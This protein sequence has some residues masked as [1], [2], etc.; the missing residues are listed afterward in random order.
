[1]LA[2]LLAIAA[3][4]VAAA[5]IAILLLRHTLP[6]RH[7][8]TLL[9]H[10]DMRYGGA[11]RAADKH[12]LLSQGRCRLSLMGYF[13]FAIDNIVDIARYVTNIADYATLFQLRRLVGCAC[14]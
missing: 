9:C 14:C 1:M 2:A 3:T 7:I 5:I 12:M 6:L 4:V 11:I 8:I 13:F 10:G